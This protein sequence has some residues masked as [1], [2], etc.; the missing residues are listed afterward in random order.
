MHLR[1]QAGIDHGNRGLD[2]DQYRRPREG[3]FTACGSSQGGVKTKKCITCI[4]I[5]KWVF[6]VAGFNK[7]IQGFF[8]STPT[9]RSENRLFL[10]ILE[11]G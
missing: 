2:G 8:E 1:Q 4:H 6:M 11:T 7:R 3:R 5:Y 9:T 10:G